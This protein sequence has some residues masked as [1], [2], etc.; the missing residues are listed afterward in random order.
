MVEWELYIAPAAMPS[1]TV[2]YRV[3][4]SGNLYRKL[5]LRRPLTKW[6]RLIGHQNLP[7]IKRIGPY[8]VEGMRLTAVRSVIAFSFLSKVW[9]SLRQAI[10]ANDCFPLDLI[11]KPSIRHLDERRI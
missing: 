4:I 8:A 3:L 10:V 11:A 2:K 5:A 6:R 7:E 9:T 1:R